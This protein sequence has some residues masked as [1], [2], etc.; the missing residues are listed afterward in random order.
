MSLIRL[1]GITKIYPPFYRALHRIT[2][3]IQRGEFILLTGPT[4]AGKTTLLKLI[5]AEEKPTEGE[6]YFEGVPYS[7]FSYKEIMALRQKMGIVFQDHK[8]FPDLTVY[9]NLEVALA[10]SKKKVKNKK[11]YL[12][13]W[14]ERFSL[15]HK[16]KKLVKELS[17]GEQQKVGLIRALIKEPSILI[18]DEPTGNLDP[19]SIGEIIELL[20]NFHREG[21]TILLSTHDPTIISKKPGRIIMLNRGELVPD[22]DIYWQT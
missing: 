1:E 18:L 9:E 6:I 15:S 21:K 22:V 4:G 17:G 16:A 3:E 11:F 20:K 5:Y 12:Y 19:F 10:L 2:L 7:N 8:L 14:L 13:E